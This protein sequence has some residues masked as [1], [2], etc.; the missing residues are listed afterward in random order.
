MK[1]FMKK[2]RRMQ[3]ACLYAGM[4]AFQSQA[5]L[6]TLTTPS[7]SPFYADF[8]ITSGLSVDYTSESS[9]TGQFVATGSNLEYTDSKDS[10]G[11][12]NGT[13]GAYSAYGFSGSYTLTAN[14]VKEANGNWD[15]STGTITIDGN[16]L[17]NGNSDVLLTASLKPGDNNIGYGT[18]IGSTLF[19]F[20]FTVTGGESQIVKD[21]IGVGT[22]QG[23]VIINAG[24]YDTNPLNVGNPGPGDTAFSG[25]F[26]TSFNNYG[27]TSSATEDTFVPEPN[28]YPLAGSVAALLG[29]VGVTVRRKQA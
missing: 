6:L 20:N 17:G 2:E 26:S 25:N 21:F 28:A 18:A 27:H 11:T 23:G 19:Y 13:T 1:T 29:F 7:T 12:G 22:G 9:T 5:A 16:L 4:V 3:A 10:P 15:V 24:G 14:L 8:G